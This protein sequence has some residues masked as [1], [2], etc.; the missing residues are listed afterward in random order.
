MSYETVKLL[1]TVAFVVLVAIT[2]VSNIR[3][4]KNKDKKDK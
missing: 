2:L 4:M 3:K 1:V